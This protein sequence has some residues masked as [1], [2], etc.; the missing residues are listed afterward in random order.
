MKPR[1]RD[2]LQAKRITSP[3]TSYYEVILSPGDTPTYIS[4][5]DYMAAVSLWDSLSLE[6]LPRASISF[7]NTIPPMLVAIAA[8]TYLEKEIV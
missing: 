3:G 7:D 1:L 2:I 5:L 8:R 4:L 6:D